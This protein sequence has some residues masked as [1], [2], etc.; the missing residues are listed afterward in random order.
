MYELGTPS[1]MFATWYPVLVLTFL[2][3]GTTVLS[4]YFRPEQ[5]TRVTSLELL[6]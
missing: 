4:R 1:L 5:V 2:P 3:G 6:H